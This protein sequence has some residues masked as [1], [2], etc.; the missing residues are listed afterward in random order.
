[1]VCTIVQE[2]CQVRPEC[3]FV[4]QSDRR[5]ASHILNWNEFICLSLKLL[6]I[7]DDADCPKDSDSNTCHPLPKALLNPTTF[8]FLQPLSLRDYLLTLIAN[9]K[10]L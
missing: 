6:I 10:P 5:L 1:M 8:I 4:S 9:S 2:S 7:Q 3:L